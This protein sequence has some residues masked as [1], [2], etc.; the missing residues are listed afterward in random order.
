MNKPRSIA[1]LLAMSVILVDG[2][3]RGGSGVPGTG[4]GASF[5]DLTWLETGIGVGSCAFACS[6]PLVFELAE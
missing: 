5:Y 1:F 3:R 4:S 2:Y 6:V